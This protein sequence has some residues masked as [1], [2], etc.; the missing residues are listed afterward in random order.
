MAKPA[1]FQNPF[2][3]HPSDVPSSLTVHEKLIGAQNYRPWRREIEIGLSTKR[4]LGFVKGTVVRLPTDANLQDL[5]DTCNNMLERRFSLSDGSR[6]YK[7]NK[8]TY[9]ITQSGCSVG[10]YYTKM[11]YVWE[12]L[13]NLN[14]LHVIARITPEIT[15]FLNVLNKQK[16]EQRL[17]QFLNGLE[18]KYSHQRSQILMIN[19][20][21]NVENACSLI[22]QEESQR[23]LFGSLSNVEATALYSKGGTK[24][25]CSICG[26]KWHP[27]KKCWEKIG[28]PAWHPKVKGSQA[29]RQVMTGQGQSRNQFVPR[30]ATHVK[31]G[32][33]SFTPQQFE[34]LL[35]SVQHMG[36]FNAAEE[37]I[38]H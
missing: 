29:N 33:I 2:Y 17:F 16:K 30:T 32:N 24:D 8:D 9:E 18:D 23:M 15:A 11:K 22:Q 13:D 14:T 19:P 3:L 5:W 4:K 37:E 7:L 1:I 27:P 25:K 36:V 26:F 31:S 6:K 35:K 34:Q 12:E 21:P 20:L 38:D 28:Y 10:E